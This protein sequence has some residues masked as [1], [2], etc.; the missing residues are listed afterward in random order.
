MKTPLYLLGIASSLLL[1]A[2]GNDNTCCHMIDSETC[3]SLHVNCQWN[4][5]L[6]CIGPNSYCQQ[7]CNKMNSVSCHWT[8]NSCVYRPSLI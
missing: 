1:F 3:N 6:G 2:N 7:L 8:G 4:Y 5:K